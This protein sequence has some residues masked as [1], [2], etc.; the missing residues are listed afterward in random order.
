MNRQRLKRKVL[1][2]NNTKTNNYGGDLSLRQEKQ[3]VIKNN[4]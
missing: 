1:L 4:N 2:C 3:K